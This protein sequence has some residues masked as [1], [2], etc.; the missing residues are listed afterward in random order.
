MEKDRHRSLAQAGGRGEMHGYANNDIQTLC[1]YITSICIGEV[2]F[3]KELHGNR[4][5]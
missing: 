1:A 5:C 2:A 3:T 4:V